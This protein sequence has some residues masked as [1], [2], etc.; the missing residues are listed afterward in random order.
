M[1]LIVFQNNDGRYCI[2][3]TQFHD[4][5]AVE[6]PRCSAKEWQ[7]RRQVDSNDGIV[8]DN[9]PQYPN[10]FQSGMSRSSSFA[11]APT[12]R[13]GCPLVGTRKKS[14]DVGSVKTGLS[15]ARSSSF[16]E[17][18]LQLQA[19]STSS[20]PVSPPTLKPNASSAVELYQSTESPVASQRSDSADSGINSP[21]M[22]L[23]SEAGSQDVCVYF[24]LED[25]E[26]DWKSV[27]SSLND[28]SVV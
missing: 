18:L 26:D 19:S 10:S 27:P 24:Q 12:V 28:P 6:M 13:V 4:T 16:T 8:V 5:R 14:H 3:F 1:P 17:T 22:K 9:E 15:R 11:S 21:V 23:L 20:P 7:Q 25:P 2:D